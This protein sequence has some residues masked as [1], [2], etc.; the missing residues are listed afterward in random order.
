MRIRHVIEILNTNNFLLLTLNQILKYYLN[1]LM[2]FFI[3]L[4]ILQRLV[5]TLHNYEKG[6]THKKDLHAKLLRYLR[7]QSIYLIS[8]SFD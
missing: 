4:Q 1:N 6:R 7:N 8:V 3:V 5:V 2:Q